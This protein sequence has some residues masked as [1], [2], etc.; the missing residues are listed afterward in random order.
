MAA[1]AHKSN[2]HEFCVGTATTDAAKQQQ[3][4]LT[5]VSEPVVVPVDRN[6]LMPSSA[7]SSSRRYFVNHQ[8]EHVNKPPLPP[9]ADVMLAAYKELQSVP[10]PSSKTTL[11]PR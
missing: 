10:F 4:P 2:N 9:L 1:V 5:V 6:S 3:Q 8:V 7:S 11:S